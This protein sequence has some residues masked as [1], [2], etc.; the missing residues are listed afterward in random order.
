MLNKVNFRNEVF[1]EDDRFVAVCYELGVSSFGGTPDEAR[2]SLLEAVSLFIEECERMGTLD[3]VLRES[4]YTRDAD[5]WQAPLPVISENL[6][7]RI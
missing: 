6:N 2:K 5:G 4:G 7:V 3:E 1:K